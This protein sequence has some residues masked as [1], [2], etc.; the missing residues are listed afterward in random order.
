MNAAFLFASEASFF[1]LNIYLIAAFK[2][3]MDNFREIEKIE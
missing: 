1:G 3:L 2:D